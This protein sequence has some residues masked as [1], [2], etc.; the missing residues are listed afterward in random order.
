MTI[1][2]LFGS[3][4][5]NREVACCLALFELQ[6]NRVTTDTEQLASLRLLEPVKLYGVDDFLPQVKAVSTRHVKI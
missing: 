2:S 5:V 1:F 6:A 3:G 4:L